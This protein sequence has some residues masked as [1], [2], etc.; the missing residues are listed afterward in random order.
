MS[1]YLSLGSN[2]GDRKA[3]LEQALGRLEAAGVQ[4]ERLSPVVESPALLPPEAPPDWNQP[5]LN[6][7]AACRAEGPPESLLRRLKAI[8]AELG[9]SDARRWSPRPIDIDILLWDDLIHSSDSLEIPHPALHER[10]FVLT[11]LTA[12]APRLRLPGYG[13]RTPLDLA[14]E[15]G[16][17]IPLWMGIVNLTPDSFS[18]GG[19]HES[20]PA[21]EQHVD[22]LLS[23][24]AQI[25][26]FGAESTRPGAT[27]LTA[28]DELERLAP[29]LERVIDKLNGRQLRPLISVD[30][31][32]P[33]VA[34]FAI[35][36]GADIINDVG[37]LLDPA[38]LEL[39]R[40]GRVEWIAMHQLSLPASR[41][42]LLPTDRDAVVQVDEWLTQ[43]IERWTRAGLDLAR[44]VFDPGIGFGKNPLQ[45][46]DLLRGFE[47]FR[48]HGLRLLVGH[49]R[50]SFMRGIAADDRH[51]RDLVTIGASL[52]LCARGIDM[53]RVHNVADHVTAYRGWAHARPPR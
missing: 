2:L 15:H 6:L 1:I 7:V 10:S 36:S 22:S 3:H 8:E 46:L 39:A 48:R 49:S 35:R 53:L 42:R 38:M 9:R 16:A 17:R 26:D 30:T 25:L 23:A 18:D 14:A 32:H 29:M 33:E 5:F 41:E 34:E 31:Y 40:D 28:A 21:V 50:K 20:W 52:E 45:S 37:G 12:L 13:G 11:P 51:E 27:P 47:R 43:Q 19:R 4:I 24:G 44:I